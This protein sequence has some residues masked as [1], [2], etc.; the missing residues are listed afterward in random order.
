MNPKLAMLSTFTLAVLGGFVFAIVAAGLYTAHVVSMPMMLG[1]TV[2]FNLVWWWLSPFVMDLTLQWVYKSEWVSAEEL[3]RTHPGVVNFIEKTCRDQNIPV[4]R[5]GLIHDQSPT[6]FTYGATARNA[7]LVVSAGIFQYLSEEEATA[8]Y[9]HELGHIV[10][11]DFIVMSVAATLVQLL[12]QLYVVFTRTKGGNGDKK[13][14]LYL[15]GLASYVFYIAGTY[16]LLFLSRTREYYAD[17]FAAESTGDPNALS[18]ALAKIAYGIVS[19]EQQV[20]KS[21]LQESVRALGIYDHKSARGVGVAYEA[22]PDTRTLGKVFLFDLFNPWASIAELN[23]THPLTGKRI[24]AL[25]NVARTLGQEPAFDFGRI[26]AEG[27]QLDMGRMRAQFAGEVGIYFAPWAGPLVG[28]AVGLALH[29]H[30]LAAV[31]AGWG[32]GMVLKGL[33]SFQP[34]EPEPKTF[35]ELMSDPYASPLKGQPVAL[36]GTLIGKAD[37]GSKISEDFMLQ[38]RTGIVYLNYES[39]FGAIGNLFFA[40]CQGNHLVGERVQADGWFRRG[41]MPQFDLGVMQ[42]SG[43]DRIKSY[44]RAWTMIPGVLV[45][46]VAGVVGVLF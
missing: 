28:L 15:V 11:R 14:N 5:L 3:G 33:Y 1:L 21:R 27:N 31:I 19:T 10:H 12:Y 2:L 45:L 41:V 23:S 17:Q 29:Q 43:G 6:A 42:T 35:L 38:D 7:R 26:A 37:A 18:T 8:V 32:A 36:E 40:W 34:G 16:M 25:A 44:T 30:V 24:R 46:A 39:F 20:G 13:G 9:A 22:Q 4:P